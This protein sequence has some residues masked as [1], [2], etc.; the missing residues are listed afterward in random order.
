MGP[1]EEARVSVT[2]QRLV[3][4][5]VLLVTGTFSLPSTAYLLDGPAT[6]N[7]ILPVQ[8]AVMA[9]VGAACALALPALAPS[10][11]ARSRRALVGA[12]WGL[13][14]A[15]LGV[16]VSWFLLSGLRGA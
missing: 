1:R 11:S 10:G 12:G 4:V 15:V 6:E 3:G 16:L 8:L 2:V 7:W 13:L 5:V 9:L 14:A